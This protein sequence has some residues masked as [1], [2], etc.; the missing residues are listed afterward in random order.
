V[1]IKVVE[2]RQIL[3]E[4]PLEKV[5]REKSLRQDFTGGEGLVSEMGY[6]LHSGIPTI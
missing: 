5:N 3:N 2:E 6:P 4:T 1:P